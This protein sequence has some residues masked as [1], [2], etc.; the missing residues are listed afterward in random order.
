MIVVDSSAWIEYLRETGS[1][2]DQTL[3]WLL[4]QGPAL[5]VTEVVV[6]ELL[7]GA[8]DDAGA[9]ALKRQLCLHRILP[10]HGLASYEAAAALSRACRTGGLSLGLAD[11]LIALPAID[12]D[13]PVLHADSDFAAMSRLTPL[14]TFPPE[15]A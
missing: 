7:A 8:P 11:C 10:L 14:K 1:P 13:A 4:K 5:A 2:T 6:G 9:Q 3:R 15:S 12:A